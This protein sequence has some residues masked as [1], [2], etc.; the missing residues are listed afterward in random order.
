MSVNVA[1]ATAESN[2]A[3]LEN[4]RVQL[5]YC[6]M[7]APISGRISMANVKVGNFVRPADTAALATINQISPPLSDQWSKYA[8]VHKEVRRLDDNGSWDKA[9]DLSTSTESNGA[10]TLFQ[11]FDDAVA[12]ARDSTGKAAVSTLS[13]LG[14]SAGWYALAVAAVALFAAWLIVR[15]IGQ[16]I[17]DY[18]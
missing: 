11:N 10:A 13:G 16:R 8:E 15:G 7:R 17:E 5:G 12:T 6:Q 3:Q 4:L 9:V 1:R 14:G 18:R 2:R